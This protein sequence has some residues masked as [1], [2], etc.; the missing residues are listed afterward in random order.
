MSD[1]ALSFQYRDFHDVPRCIVFGYMG[2]SYLLD[3]PFDD[4][5]DD[6]PTEYG[7]Y[8]L[9]LPV[10]AEV[11]NEAWAKISSLGV[12]IGTIPV[13]DVMFDPTRRSTFRSKVLLDLL[14]KGQ[15]RS[16]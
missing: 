14:K 1:E 9:S 12:R 5:A 15:A 11:P 13:R 16:R 6:Y 2:S 3:C 10:N 4:A 7:V 8:K